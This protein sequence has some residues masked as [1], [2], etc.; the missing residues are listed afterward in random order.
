[1][2]QTQ[3]QRI[4]S[5]ELFAVKVA[6]PECSKCEGTGITRAYA[7]GVVGHGVCLDC[8]AEYRVIERQAQEMVA[9]GLY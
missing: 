5:M 2:K 7:P 8:A 3:D 1:M 4:A 9:A 6:Q